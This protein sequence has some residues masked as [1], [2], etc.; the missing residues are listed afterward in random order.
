MTAVLKIYYSISRME[1]ITM[2]RHRFCYKNR[3]FQYKFI[4]FAFNYAIFLDNHFFYCAIL[5]YFGIQFV[6]PFTT[7]LVS[8]KCGLSNLGVDQPSHQGIGLYL[9]VALP[10]FVR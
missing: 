10:H 6:V 2:K 8:L 4:L 9:L 3:S 7:L 1:S 5:K